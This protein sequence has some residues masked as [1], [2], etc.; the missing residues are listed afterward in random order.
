MGHVGLCELGWDEM[1]MGGAQWDGMGWDRVGWSEMDWSDMGW[2]GLRR[3][4][5]VLGCLRPALP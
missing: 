2:C 1:R 5:M 4:G 3:D